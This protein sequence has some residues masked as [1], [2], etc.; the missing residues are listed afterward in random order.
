MTH[1]AVNDEDWDWGCQND[2]PRNAYRYESV[3]LGSHWHRSNW[4]DHCQIPGDVQ[5]AD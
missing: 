5:E 3:G 2:R 1:L 4:V